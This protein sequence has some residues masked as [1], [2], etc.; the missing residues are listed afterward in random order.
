MNRRYRKTIIAGNWKMNKTATE[1]KKFAEE[2]KTMLPKAK[3]CDVVVCVPFV[4]IPAAI[5]AFKDMRVAIG[6]E[7]LFYDI[8]S[9]PP[10]AWHMADIPA[11]RL[12]VGT[13]VS[14]TA[15]T[16]A[17]P[18]NLVIRHIIAHVKNL[19]VSPA[20]PCEQLLIHI[21]F[22]RTAHKYVLDT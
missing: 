5:R 10:S 19:I 1:T 13:G 11:H 4:N 9:T 15:G 6:A 16:A 18:H 12:Y 20:I 22:D 21:N 14:R 3:W 2:L 17:T 7:N 8:T